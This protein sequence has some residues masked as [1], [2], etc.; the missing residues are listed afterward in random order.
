MLRNQGLKIWFATHVNQTITESLQSIMLLIR[1][2]KNSEALKR[3]CNA[4]LLKRSNHNR[5]GQVTHL[6]NKQKQCDWLLPVTI[7][8]ESRQKKVKKKN[9]ENICQIK[10][11]QKNQSSVTLFQN[12]TKEWEGNLVCTLLMVITTQEDSKYKGKRLSK[13]ILAW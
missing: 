7:A 4:G 12:D 3:S 9:R 13:E 2:D 6:H 10:W 1:R 5:E 11:G 8:W